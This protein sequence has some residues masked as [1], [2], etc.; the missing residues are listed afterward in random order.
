[1]TTILSGVVKKLS[2]LQNKPKRASG[3]AVDFQVS[4]GM[5]QRQAKMC[6]TPQSSP[7]KVFQGQE[8]REDALKA[9]WL[10]PTGVPLYHEVDA[11][12]P[13][14]AVSASYIPV[15]EAIKDDLSVWHT[16]IEYDYNKDGLTDHLFMEVGNL[17][18]RK[19]IQYVLCMSKSGHYRR[20]ITD[21][22]TSYDDPGF[23]EFKSDISQHEDTP[24]APHERE[25]GVTMYAPDL[26]KILLSPT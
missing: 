22:K 5:G 26:L 9:C 15:K 6:S 1:M 19:N 23:A 10:K 25:R 20:H 17:L 13:C 16:P 24:S 11:P 4:Y 8:L 12:K 3:W 21:I 18:H 7:D 14:K 2:S